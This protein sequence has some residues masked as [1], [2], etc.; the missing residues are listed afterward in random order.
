[1]K[2][3]NTMPIKDRISYIKSEV[4]ILL[5]K[6]NKTFAD[7]LSLRSLESHL[8]ELQAIQMEMERSNPLLDV[9]ELRLKGYAVD[10][11]NI[12][13]EMLSIFSSGIAGVI[14]KATHK[15]SSGNDSKKVPLEIKSNL[16]MRLANIS[17]GSTRLTITLSTGQC[18]L[19]ETVSSRALKEVIALLTSNTDDEMMSQVAEIGFN[20]TQS[21]RKIISEC[22]KNDL[23]FDF[24]WV[25]PFS[26]GVKLVEVTPEKIK[27][28]N[29]GLEQTI[30]SPTRDEIISGELVVLS[31]Y[32]KLEIESEGV[33]YKLAFPPDFFPKIQ[34]KCRVGEL[35]KILASVTDINNVRL[36]IQRHNYT[37]KSIL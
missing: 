19:F 18:E 5:N 24:S 20:S 6:K 33:R 2:T 26:D 1:M 30:V 4:N 37:V 7:S 10:L 27:R 34:Q 12:P 36:G 35:I 13:L 23:H 14:Q 8:S 15:I 29:E 21:M 28:F 3:N 32:G 11:G 31:V 17:P 9:I 25:G 16:D 22:I